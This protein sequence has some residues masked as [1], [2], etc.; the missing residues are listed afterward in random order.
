[1]YQLWD[2]LNQKLKNVADD[3]DLAPRK[4]SKTESLKLKKLNSK[5]I[6]G[7]NRRQGI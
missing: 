4:T 7:L 5:A 1:L 3:K 6:S 2:D